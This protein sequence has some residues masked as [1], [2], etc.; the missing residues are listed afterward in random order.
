MKGETVPLPSDCP[1]EMQP[2]TLSMDAEL[3]AP[4]AN[5]QNY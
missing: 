4:D 5:E 1:Q 3:T 2:N